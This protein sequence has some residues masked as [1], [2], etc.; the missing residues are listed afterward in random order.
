MPKPVLVAALVLSFLLFSGLQMTASAGESS[1]A[2]KT[3]DTFVYS[4]SGS[5]LSNQTDVQMPESIQAQFYLQY[6]ACAILE[7]NGVTVTVNAS[8][9][10]TTG[11]FME[12]ATADYGGGYVPFYIPAGL[13][14]GSVVP[15]TNMESSPVEVCYVNDTITRTFGSQ[16]RTINHLD[17]A[18]TVE[19]FPNVSCNAYWDQNTGVLTQV[20]YAYK[21][22]TG[23]TSTTW[24]LTLKLTET[25]LF[26]VSGPETAQPSPTVPELPAAIVAF[27]IAALTGAALLYRKRK[28]N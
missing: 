23:D 26:T 25:S 7:V 20:D 5:W 9:F 27:P 8:S 3:G 10:Y 18:F 13:G 15:N 2:V 11:I 12:I 19:G 6:I 22:Q 14:V 17:I 4:C 28:A 16:P 24:T 1:L 21:N